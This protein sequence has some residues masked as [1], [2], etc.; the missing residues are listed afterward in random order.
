MAP[1]SMQDVALSMAFTS[2]RQRAS[3]RV[4]SGSVIALRL[5]CEATGNVAFHVA[6]HV[7]Y[8]D[9]SSDPSTW[10]VRLSTFPI[11]LTTYGLESVNIA[12]QI[13]C[14]RNTKTHVSLGFAKPMFTKVYVS[15]PKT[16]K[17]PREQIVGRHSQIEIPPKPNEATQPK[18]SQKPVDHEARWPRGL[19]LQQGTHPDPFSRTVTSATIST[20]NIRRRDG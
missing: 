8:V 5:F 6:F 10:R 15:T 3:R 7:A 20:S 1:P 2:G 19:E 16:E 18:R 14:I 13:V 12:P 4:I 11:H 17:P 9:K